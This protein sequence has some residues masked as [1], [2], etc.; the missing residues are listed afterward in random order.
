M[1]KLSTR[2]NRPPPLPCF[3]GRGEFPVEKS[4]HPASH[5]MDAFSD[6]IKMWFKRYQPSGGL[7]ATPWLLLALSQEAQEIQEQVDEV[8]IQLQ[9]GI[10]GRPLQHGLVTLIGGVEGLDFLGIVSG[11]A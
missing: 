8:Q 2:W 1:S 7:P 3:W 4:I 9:G 5:R 11:K 10:D 6:T